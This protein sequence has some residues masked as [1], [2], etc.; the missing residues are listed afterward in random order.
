MFAGYPVPVYI[1]LIPD[2]CQH[3]SCQSKLSKNVSNNVLFTSYKFVTFGHPTVHRTTYLIVI[4]VNDL[5]PNRPQIRIWF[6]ILT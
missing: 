5:A 3:V 4:S 2:A 1:S 6:G